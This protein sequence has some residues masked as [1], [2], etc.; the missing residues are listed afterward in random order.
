VNRLT[1]QLPALQAA[2][3][4]STA[5]GPVAPAVANQ[6]D[7]LIRAL[8]RK[9]RF[10]EM[11][12]A[13][14]SGIDWDRIDDIGRRPGGVADRAHLRVPLSEAFLI[15]E[16]PGA[17]IDHVYLAF[18]GLT[19]ALVNLTDTL[20]RLVNLAYGLGIDAKR[21]SLLAVRDQCAPTSTLGIVLHDVQYTDWLRKVR[22]LRGR[23]QHA[24]VEEIL[25]TRPAALSRRG[26]PYV[27]QAY[28]WRSPAQ[29]TSIVTYAQEAVQAADSCL[30]AAIGGILAN[31]ISPMR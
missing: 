14:L 7:A 19:A 3:V 12:M 30:D 24:D 21:A 10:A 2:M 11:H 5:G 22:D 16:H 6:V 31:P 27:D 4:P 1:A 18:D 20:G 25:T 26:E 8:S 13:L 15:I 28:S 17:V 9:A 29:S 23:C